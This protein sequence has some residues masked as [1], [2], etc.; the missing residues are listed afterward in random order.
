MLTKGVI[1]IIPTRYDSSRFPGKPLAKISGV[2]MI[3]RVFRQVSQ[4]IPQDQILVATDNQQIAEVCEAAGAGVRMTPSDCPTGT[5]RIWKAV[6]DID[7]EIVVNVQ[8]DEPLVDPDAIRAIIEDKRANPACV[9]NAMSRINDARD[10]N[11]PNVPKVVV[12]RTGRLVYMSRAPIPYGKTTEPAPTYY[13]QVCIYAFDKTQLESFGTHGGKSP[14]EEPEDIE[15]LRFVDLG[16]PVRMVKVQAS[17]VAVD[18]PEDILRVEEI[19]GRPR[20]ES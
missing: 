17:S 20:P 12:D 3:I 7:S 2:P 4:A 9:I 13:R 11:S 10:V 14:L 5:D 19:I 8:G 1:A 15:I 6:Q 16:I 18:T